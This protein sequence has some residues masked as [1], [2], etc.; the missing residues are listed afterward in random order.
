VGKKG[1]NNQT[2]IR[3]LSEM[4]DDKKGY[5]RAKIQTKHRTNH[6]VRIPMER[7]LKGGGGWDNNQRMGGHSL[8][9]G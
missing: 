2:R 9:G 8:M 5:G 7:S 1:R 6:W 4:L 3:R